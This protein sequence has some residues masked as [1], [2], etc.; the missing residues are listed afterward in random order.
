MLAHEVGIKLAPRTIL[1]NLREC[2]VLLG[3]H[4]PHKL[5]KYRKGKMKFISR[6]LEAVALA[7]SSWFSYYFAGKGE[8]NIE[9]ILR[10]DRPP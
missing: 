2:D 9:A 3:P 5:G 1:R 8:F 4:R 10:G 6:G 7:F